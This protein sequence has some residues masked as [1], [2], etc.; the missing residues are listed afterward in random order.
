FLVVCAVPIAAKWLLIGRWRARQIRLWSLDYV[1][2]W[3]VKTLLRSNPGPYLFV[4]TPLYG[5]YLRALGAKVG[6]GVVILSRRVPI[7]TD[8]L[9]IG[10]G[11]LIRREVSF[12]GYRA[13]AGRIEIGPVTLGR[14]VFVGE[15][16]VLDIGTSMGDGAQLGH[17]SALLSGQAVP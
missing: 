8:L 1:R 9:T 6:P 7:C 17:T 14:D 10:A 16:A 13:Q 12:L 5:L 3:I 11:T 15:M 2:F 4:G